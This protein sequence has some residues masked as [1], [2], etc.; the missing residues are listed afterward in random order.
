MKAARLILAIALLAAGAAAA[1]EK[2]SIGIEKATPVRLE[3][4]FKLGEQPEHLTYQLKDEAGLCE[5][6]FG[7]QILLETEYPRLAF[8]SVTA[9]IRGV[10]MRLTL[11]TTLWVSREGG[12]KVQAHEEAHRAICEAFYREAEKIAQAIA[13]RAK[14]IQQGMLAE[15]A[16]AVHERCAFAQ[17][18]FDELTDHGRTDIANDVAMEKAMAEERARA[19]AK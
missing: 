17:K 15:Y 1:P 14:K 7:L 5:Y 18:R 2:G 10:K 11:E 9:T 13:G 19:E 4:R 16:K 3:Q 6:Q 8:K 12:A